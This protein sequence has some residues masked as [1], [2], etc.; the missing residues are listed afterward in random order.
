M[1]VH[2]LGIYA[3]CGVLSMNQMATLCYLD[4]GITMVGKYIHTLDSVRSSAETAGSNL[5]EHDILDCE[6]VSKVWSLCTA[7]M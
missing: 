1:L 7:Y 3:Y 4:V 2:S 6:P 5:Q